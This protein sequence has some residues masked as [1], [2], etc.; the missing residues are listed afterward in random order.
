MADGADGAVV[1]ADDS[2]GR[3]AGDVGLLPQRH[4]ASLRTGV[5]DPVPDFGTGGRG[6]TRTGDLFLCPAD[7]QRVEHGSQ[8]CRA[9]GGASVL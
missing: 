4:G 5:A 8:R 3:D 7:P 9:A 2:G 6:V 1:D